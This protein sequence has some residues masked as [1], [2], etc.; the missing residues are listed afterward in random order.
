MRDGFVRAILAHTSTPT[1]TPLPT[2]TTSDELETFSTSLT[3]F[4]SLFHPSS[5]TSSSEPLPRSVPAGNPLYLARGAEGDVKVLYDMK[6]KGEGLVRLGGKD[7]GGVVKDRRI[8]EAL[9]E[10]YL[11]TGK[12]ASEEMRERV[13]EG[14][15]GVRKTTGGMEVGMRGWVGMKKVEVEVK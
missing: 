7:D 14:W 2:T 13:W 5:S 15:E 1:P 3:S 12:V 10:G 9:W 6:W 11:G 4:K 8:S